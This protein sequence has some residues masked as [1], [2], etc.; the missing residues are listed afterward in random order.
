MDTPLPLST[1]ATH[2]FED[3]PSEFDP[4]VISHL[5]D[6]QLFIKYEIKQ[7]VEDIW[8]ARY[9]RVALQF[10]DLLLQDAPRIF[11]AL[12]KGLQSFNQASGQ[13]ATAQQ[14]SID[15]HTSKIA[16]LYIGSDRPPAVKLYI[17]AD[18]SYGS[19]CVDE[20]AAEHVSADV[21]VHY[22]RAC[23]S[24][25][26]RIPVIHVFTIQSLD[27]P[28][29]LN[30]FRG[31]Y[32]DLSSN[33]I[34]MADVTYQSHLIHLQATLVQ[35]GYTS[36]FLTEIL[37][38]PSSP[39]PNRT[40]P[41]EV[42][43][44]PSALKDWH[45]LHLSDPPES[46]LLTLASHV[47]SIRIFPTFDPE[48]NV[49]RESFHVSTSRALNKRYA[50]MTSVATVSIFGILINTLSVKNYLHIVDHVKL[51]ILAAGKKSYTFVVGKINVA[52]VANFSEIG[53][54]VVIGCWESSLIDSKDFWR[55]IL[56][57]FELGLA[58][59]KDEER[60]WTGQWSSD[61]QTILNDF[62]K[63]QPG[64]TDTELVLQNTSS[65]SEQFESESEAESA[66]PEF[67]LRTG[68]YVSKS[69]PMRTLTASRTQCPEGTDAA[70]S[71]SLITRIKEDLAV[72]A[73]EV[74]PGAEHL[75]S[76]RTWKGLGSDFEIAYERV[77]ADVEQ[78][79]SGIARGYTSGQETVKS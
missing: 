76:A 58:L 16:N 42:K 14:V 57:P 60:L 49:S 44:D 46:L 72:V 13:A 77:G 21:V 53:A 9:S 1:S 22:G 34:L 23:L 61:F 74:S 2:I 62:K 79:R 4:G 12:N 63:Q 41:D 38:D 68:R 28:A 5:S 37:Y 29:F 55:P 67:D 51:Q 69:R 70:R 11:E 71:N 18:T 54:W 64:V 73:G 7:T 43:A 19:C 25:T 20:I 78:G 17:L 59:T 3:H 75:R 10:P 6:E 50:I 65:T 45:L 32:T 15:D 66:P 36:I 40:L 31:C 33:I 52:K 24:P 47:A 56:T 27:R 30:D 48:M 35:L 26:S 8:Q 39:L